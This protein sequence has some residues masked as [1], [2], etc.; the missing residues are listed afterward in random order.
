[1][2]SPSPQAKFSRVA[3]NDEERLMEARDRQERRDEDPWRA[4]VT[5]SLQ[6]MDIQ[7]Q[8]MQAQHAS[9]KISVDANTALTTTIKTNTDAIV[10]FFTAAQGFFKV[11]G[12]AGKIAKW[13][14]AV[15]AAIGVV[16]AAVHFGSPKS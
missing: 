10:D 14:T 8:E 2:V 11:A 3:L 1:M 16:L 15:A 5:Q 9:L 12:M 13:I 6:V 7:M 4:D